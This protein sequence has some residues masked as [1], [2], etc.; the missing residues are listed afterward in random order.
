MKKISTA[1]QVFLYVAPFPAL[2]F[3]KIWASLGVTISSL[4]LGSLVLFCYCCAIIALA[5]RWDKPTYFD[6]VVGGY[7]ALVSSGL[8]ILP[9]TFGPFLI[10]YAVTGIYACLFAAA[11]FPPLF[12]YEPFTYHYAKK[13]TPREFWDNPLFLRINRIITLAWSAIFA[14]A[15]ASSL[16]PSVVTRALIPLGLILGVGLPISLR[17]P[18]YY[19]K[20]Q[21]LPSRA[22]LRKIDREAKATQSLAVASVSLPTSAWETISRMPDFFNPEA[23]GDLN[24]VIGFVVFGSENFEAYLSIQKGICSLENQPSH[25]P[26]LVIRTP[27]GV[28]LAIARRE[29]DGQ[30]AFFQKA[31]QAEGDLGLLLRMKQIFRG[32]SSS[33]KINEE[34]KK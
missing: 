11:F 32:P 27:A 15:I 17:F 7:F 21:G 14:V 4:T 13:G 29:L 8:L 3:F 6:W 26:D 31:Y 1:R 23:A 30:Q 24:A 28:W 25:T 16:Y 20:K 19:L 34:G 33:T 10:D 12:G 2:A 5:L 18:D 22:E 9:G